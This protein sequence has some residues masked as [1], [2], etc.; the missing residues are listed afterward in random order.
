MSHFLF[1]F[2]CWKCLILK[3]QFCFQ[4]LLAK[5]SVFS[6][7]LSLFH[8]W[9]PVKSPSFLQ[10]CILLRYKHSITSKILSV[11]IYQ[12]KV[13][14]CLTKFSNRTIINYD[15]NRRL[16]QPGKFR[17]SDRAVHKWHGGQAAE[18]Q[19]EWMQNKHDL[20]KQLKKPGT[21]GHWCKVNG[22]IW[23]KPFRMYQTSHQT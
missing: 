18:W 17:C 3:V 23:R 14:K 20:T 16:K 10:V 12:Q 1:L 7:L 2:Q 6:W 8:L 11:N 19:T 21:A 4:I 9:F 13:F 15:E 5:D 22:T